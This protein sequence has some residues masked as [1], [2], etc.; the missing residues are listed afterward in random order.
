MGSKTCALI[1]AYSEAQTIVEVVQRTLKQV[2]DVLV[3]DD[4]STDKTG[5]LAGK[6]GAMVYR[7][8]INMGKGQA[9]KNGFSYLNSRHYDRIITLDAD[10][11]H[12]PEEIPLFL[13]KL[14]QGNDIVIGKRNFQ[15]ECVPRVRRFSNTLYARVLSAISKKQVYDPECGYRAFQKELLP[16][17]VGLTTARGFSYESE[18]LMKLLLEDAKISWVDISTVYI[19]G[20][21]SKINPLKHTFDSIEVILQCL[22]DKYRQKLKG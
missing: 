13:G 8:E 17:L 9:L 12:K 15:E 3:V 10:L 20:R 1:C 5:E 4:G 6:A 16:K 14:D 7:H 19:T 2:R 22:I 18:L 21:E 11:Q